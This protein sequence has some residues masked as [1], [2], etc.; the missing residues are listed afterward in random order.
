MRLMKVT[1][2]AA[3]ALSMGF[4][5]QAELQNVTVDGS[6]RI[7]GNWYNGDDSFADTSFVEQRTRLGVNADFTDEVSARIEFDAYHV[8]GAN[9]FRSD[10]VT[11]ADNLRSDG[12]SLYQGYIQAD[13]MWGTPLS[14]RL[15]RQELAFGSQWLVGVN[16]ASSL[17]TGL[18]FD[19]FRLTYGADEFSVDLWAAKLAEGFDEPFDSDVSYYGLYFSWLGLE[20]VVIDAYWMWVRDDGNGG[21]GVRPRGYR[22]ADYHTLGLRGAGTINAFD[23]EAEAAYQFGE[24]TD[25]GYGGLFGTN[26]FRT[27]YDLDVNA[28]GV[29]L[30]LG[31]TFD[32][33]WQP[34]LYAGFAFLEGGDQGSDINSLW[35]IVWNGWRNDDR[36]L[37]FNRMFSN[38]E[39]SEFLENTDLSNVFIYRLGLSVM[40]TES[41]SLALAATYF[42]TD[43]EPRDIN[44]WWD[45]LGLFRHTHDD[46]L[47]IEVGL[48]ADYAYSEDLTFRAGWAHFFGDDA[49]GDHNMVTLNGLRPFNGDRDDDYDYLFFEAEIAF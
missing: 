43:E 33:N 2:L 31:Y 44:F 48:Y 37:S 26:L 4:A 23:F 46:K 28:L 47:G 25:F 8:W 3:L 35:D 42:V 1:L 9:N 36:D 10:Y 34:R 12:V 6:I 14:M 39:Y 30:E 22:D 29:N 41:L 40:P 21:Y 11:G 13:E 18:S 20:D 7:R 17:F 15:G 16:D 32:A 27:R 45:V 5:A 38:W 19:A 49:L 24:V